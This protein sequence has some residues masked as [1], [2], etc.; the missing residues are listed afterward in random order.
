MSGGLGF[1]PCLATP[2]G[3]IKRKPITPS[4]SA[5]KVCEVAKFDA[6]APRTDPDLMC[7]AKSVLKHRYTTKFDMEGFEPAEGRLRCDYY[8]MWASD[9][10]LNR[11]VMEDIIWVRERYAQAG[12]EEPDD[13]AV[14][15]WYL[16]EGD[17]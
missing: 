5:F 1:P 10:E 9:E 8:F 7:L 15:S 3:V 11:K 16:E 6:Q 14:I 13:N 2:A 12:R 17:L 4:L